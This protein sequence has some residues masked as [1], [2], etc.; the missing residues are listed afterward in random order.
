MTRTPIDK[1]SS[2]TNICPNKKGWY[3]KKEIN[4]IPIG[5]KKYSGKKKPNAM[6]RRSPG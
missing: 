3:A 5:M 2:G 6:D 4:P 1:N